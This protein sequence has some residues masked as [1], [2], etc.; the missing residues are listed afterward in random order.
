[1]SETSR[2]GEKNVFHQP[3]G[4]E[5]WC[6]SAKRSPIATQGTVQDSELFVNDCDKYSKMNFEIYF[7]ITFPILCTLPN[8][9]PKWSLT[10]LKLLCVKAL[11]A[12]ILFTKMMDYSNAEF[13]IKLLTVL[14]AS[15]TDLKYHCQFTADLPNLSS[16]LNLTMVGKHCCR[17]TDSIWSSPIPRKVVTLTRTNFRLPVQRRWDFLSSTQYTIWRKQGKGKE[18]KERSKH[19]AEVQQS[20]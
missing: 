4:Q 12:S 10:A 13:D 1:M 16:W 20:W 6:W 11:H 18:K 8:Q 2:R 3:Y 5:R 15:I 9:F 19:K 14:A 7:S 17:C